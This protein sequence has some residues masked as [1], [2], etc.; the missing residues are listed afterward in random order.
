MV[1]AMRFWCQFLLVSHLVYRWKLPKKTSAEW[2]SQKNWLFFPFCSTFCLTVLRSLKTKAVA[3]PAMAALFPISFFF[4]LFFSLFI[5]ISIEFT[6]MIVLHLLHLTLF[7]TYICIFIHFCSCAVCSVR[8]LPNSIYFVISHKN[9]L[10]N[11]IQIVN[12]EVKIFLISIYWC[13]CCNII[14]CIVYTS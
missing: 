9:Q 1:L 2:F 12:M 3:A 7:S 5:N 13:C 4:L 10:L 6:C 11:M 8:S 14:Y